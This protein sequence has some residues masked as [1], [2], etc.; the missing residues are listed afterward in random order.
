MKAIKTILAVCLLSLATAAS[1]QKTYVHITTQSGIQ[2]D[3]AS[4]TITSMT[5]DTNAPKGPTTGTAK[6]KLDGTNEVDVTWVQLWENGPKWA[7]INVGVT[8]TSATGTDLYGGY[9]CWGK[10]TSKDSDGKYDDSTSTL[11]DTNDTATQFWGSNWKMPTSTDLANLLSTDYTDGGTWV[12]NYNSVSVNGLLVKG[13]TGTDYAENEVF[14]PAAG[15]YYGGIFGRGSGGNYW[16]S[17][18]DD[19]YYAF[20]LS[21]NSARQSVSRSNKGSGCSVRAVVAE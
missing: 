2:Y 13:K 9:Y 20:Y 11:G 21:F 18:P 15:Y 3:I 17:T 4:D 19:G 7:S 5:M 16:S 8:S 12:T 10:T 6:A 14:F 1:A